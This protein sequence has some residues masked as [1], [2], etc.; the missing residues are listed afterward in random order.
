VAEDPR[1]SGPG[2]FGAIA[3]DAEQVTLPHVG[4]ALYEPAG[5]GLGRR[6]S[7]HTP[8]TY[9]YV[10][11]NIARDELFSIASTLD[12]RATAMP[13][14]WRVA[15]AG[16]LT[17]ARIDP[18]DALRAMGLDGAT[19]ALPA[20]YL[21]ASAT[22]SVEQGVDVGMTVTFRQPDSDA[23]G[24]PVILHT[25]TIRDVAVDTTPDPARVS[26]GT[27]T[28]RYSAGASE[29]TWTESGRSWSV[30]GDLDLAQLVAIAS[31]V[32]EARG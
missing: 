27:T 1:W 30:Q 9:L 26:I 32:L 4:P 10:E 5:D 18:S 25:G 2:P 29:L 11:S 12:V 3:L 22:R 16:A 21:P 20:G 31:S 19:I 15:H 6:L 13:A 17:L 14:A 24:P 7:I 28:G 8:T 23:V